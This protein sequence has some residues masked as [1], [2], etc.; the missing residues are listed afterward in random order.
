MNG[1]DWIVFRVSDTGIGLSPEKLVRLFQDFT[2][3]DAS[4]TRKFGGTGLGL[5]LTRRFCQ[6][7]GGDVTVRSVQGEGSTFT[8]HLPAVVHEQA[9]EHKAETAEQT[10]SPGIGDSEALPEPGTCVLVID[11]DVSQRDLMGR[12]LTGEGYCVR[13][14]G[15]GEEGLRLARQLVPLAIT[16]DVMMPEM[17]GWLVLE[18]LKSDMVLREIPVIMLSMVDDLERGVT[19]GAADYLT[20]PVNRRR[21]SKILERY[22][23]ANPPCPMLIVEDDAQTRASMRTMLEKRGCRVAEAENGVIA[24]A[25]MEVERPSLIFLDLVMPVMDGFAFADKV[26]L[27]SDWRS[28]PI[29]VVTAHDLTGEER[30]RLNG[31]VETVIQKSGLSRDELMQHVRAALEQCAPRVAALPA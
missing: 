11:D 23:C 20:K 17:D 7:M 26:R 8:I 18:A 13:T 5:A 14:A 2:Q 21:L 12:F 22:T 19:L 4:T 28:I 1:I 24:L 3:A 29:V 30:R 25:M 15:S 16:L 27:H 6:M 31:Y 10:P 9:P